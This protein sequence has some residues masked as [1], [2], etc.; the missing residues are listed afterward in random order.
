[1]RIVTCYECRKKYNYDEDGFCPR[2]GSFNQVRK[3]SY[4][5][6]ANGDIVRVD[7]INERGHAGS[8]VHKEYHEEERE[9]K[10]MGLDRDEPKRAAVRV[11]KVQEAGASAERPWV[12][13][14]GK[15]KAN[16]AGV[17]FGIIWFAVVWMIIMTTIFEML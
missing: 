16:P 4:T 17:V 12:Q 14:T 6:A 7:G 13:D 11:R 10:K 5:T 9:R 8:F 1:M 15:K 3:G 2:C